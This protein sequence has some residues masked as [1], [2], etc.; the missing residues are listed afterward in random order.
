MIA[1]IAAYLSGS[2]DVIQSVLEHFESGCI[3][4]HL[5]VVRRTLEVWQQI[6]QR[7]P[8]LIR[9]FLCYTVVAFI[10]KLLLANTFDSLFL[11]T[12]LKLY[13]YNS[14]QISL[15]LLNKLPWGLLSL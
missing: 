10:P 4:T 15:R 7:S 2:Y 1:F 8:H 14:F 9:I 13:N 6:V 5:K 12:H 3:S 11:I